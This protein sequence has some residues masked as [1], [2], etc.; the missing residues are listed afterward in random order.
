LDDDD[1]RWDQLGDQ[2]QFLCTRV[3][4]FS[5]QC[6]RDNVDVIKSFGIP[7]WS[8]TEWNNFEQECNGIFSSAVVTH[9]D[10]SND[11]HKDNDSNPWTY[12]LFSYIDRSTGFPVVPQSLVSGHGFRFPDFNCEIDFGTAPGIIEMIWPSNTIEHH[13][14]FPPQPLQS[15]RTITHFGCSFQICKKLVDRAKILKDLSAKERQEKTLCRQKRKYMEVARAEKKAK[16]KV[17]NKK[18][19]VAKQKGA[20]IL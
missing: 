9:A 14:T 11:A 13:T 8:N 20:K 16:D 17:Q 19:S 15:T 10:F 18:R 12:G 1:L 5:K 6:F 2:N 4:H 7:S 3:Q